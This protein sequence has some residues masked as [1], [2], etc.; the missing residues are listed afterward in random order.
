MQEKKYDQAINAYKNAL[1]RNPNDDETRYNLAVAQKNLKKE[2]QNQKDNKDKNK[3]K[4]NKI[5]I[6]DNALAVFLN[7]LIS[8]N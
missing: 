4:K 6:R 8:R 3:D 7:F 2:Q 1:R 5:P